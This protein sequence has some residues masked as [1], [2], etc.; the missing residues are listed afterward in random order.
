[1]PRS[2]Y[3]SFFAVDTVLS[4]AMIFLNLH[5]RSGLARIT[6]LGSLAL[7]TP[8]IA[9]ILIATLLLVGRI[10]LLARNIAPIVP[11][12][13]GIALGYF[14]IFLALDVMTP[15]SFQDYFVRAHEDRK[16]WLAIMGPYVASFVVSSCVYLAVRKRGTETVT[17]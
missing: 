15:D 6:I 10:R 3:W 17:S 5:D 14:F 7:R 12:A 13:F 1:M 4:V 16:V 8:V 2:A 9:V 11:Y